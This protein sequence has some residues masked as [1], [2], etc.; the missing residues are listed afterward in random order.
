MQIG[1]MAVQIAH[2]KSVVRDIPVK[3]EG[4]TE[5]PINIETTVGDFLKTKADYAD[6]TNLCEVIVFFV[7]LH[8]N[9]IK[10]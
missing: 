1:R 2:G 7:Y 6:L 4:A 10:T 8:F 5:L 3:R 9:I